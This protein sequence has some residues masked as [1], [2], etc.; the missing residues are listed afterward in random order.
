MQKMSEE[1][2]IKLAQ[3][4]DMDIL[5]SVEGIID[6]LSCRFAEYVDK[7]EDPQEAFDMLYEE[8]GE[9]LLD[10]FV[11]TLSE[12]GEDWSIGLGNVFDMVNLGIYAEKINDLYSI[13]TVSENDM[14]AV[15]ESKTIKAMCNC[16]CGP[17]LALESIL[18]DLGLY[19][20]FVV[21]GADAEP[22]L[23][24]L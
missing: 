3:V 1:K 9:G 21:N 4:L 19:G 24:L 13:Q 12:E 23:E 18:Y 8:I 15:L 16:G 10:G 22:R 5:T 2:R 11:Y 14:C 20:V 6:E 17:K 7:I